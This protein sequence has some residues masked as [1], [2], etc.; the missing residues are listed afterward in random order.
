MM[1][2]TEPVIVRFPASVD[3]I[4]SVNQP[5]CGSGK[6]V[7][8]VRSTI[9]AGTLLTMLQSRVV[10]DTKIGMRCRFHDGDRLEQGACQSGAFG[11][12][13]DDEQAHEK[14]EESP[15]HLV[16]HLPRVDAS[17]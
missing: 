13:D 10:T 4:A 2:A 15:V 6:P 3:A 16:V 14:Y 17:A 8:S 1:L 5:V 9:T 11:S 7:T 12:T